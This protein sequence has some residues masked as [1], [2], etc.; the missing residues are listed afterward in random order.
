M[1]CPADITVN[2]DADSCGANI[3][4]PQPTYV[5]N[6]GS[7]TIINSVNQTADASGYYPVGTTNVIWTATDDCGNISTC[8][9]TVTVIDN[10]LPEI[11]C[12]DSIVSCSLQFN[13][14]TPNVSD[15]CGVASVTNDAPST[16][17]I[18]LTVV[19]WTVTDIHGN[20]ASCTQ[21]VHVSTLNVNLEGTTVLTCFNSDDGVIMVTVTGGVEPYTY[22]INGGAPQT[23]NIFDSLPA[24]NYIIT[25]YDVN[26]CQVNENYT[27]GNQDPLEVKVGKY[28]DANC[29]GKRNG[30]IGL[31]VNGGV[32]PY[33]YSWSNGANYRNH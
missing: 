3:S 16:F 25:V 22:L 21:N 30:E 29:A 23:S 8:T 13:L 5:E 15:N 27:I 14:G 1:T 12:P 17:P 6:C 18:G 33:D 31:D 10:E 28:T 32:G 20:M 7:V 26:Q 9:M 4:I 11:I 24:G 2:N 19:T